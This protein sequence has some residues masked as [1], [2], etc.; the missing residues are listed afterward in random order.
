MAVKVLV[1]GLGGQGVILAS[2]LVA[3]SAVKESHSVTATET[4]GMSQ[5][6]GAVACHV[7]IDA[8]DAPL[9]QRGTADLLLALDPGEA[10]RNLTFLRPKGACLVNTAAA[11]PPEVLPHLRRLGINV[12]TLDATRLAREAGIPSA[13]NVALVGFA[14][15]H[16]LLPLAAPSLEAAL[17]AVL[18]RSLDANRR[19]LAAGLRAGRAAAEAGA[20]STA[21]DA[22]PGHGAVPAPPAPPAPPNG[23]PMGSDRAAL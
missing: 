3:W 20:R 17:A 23:Q 15:A 13:A 5:R 10:V 11:L 8:G 6:G 22:A 14:A 9:I 7:A 21:P 19:A 1:A 12:Q 18:H 4:H 16:R 2:R